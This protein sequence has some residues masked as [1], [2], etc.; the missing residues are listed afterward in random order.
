[1]KYVGP[2]DPDRLPLRRGV[3]YRR[4]HST[5]CRHRRLLGSRRWSSLENRSTTGARLL[6]ERRGDGGGGGPYWTGVLGREDC[7]QAAT[8]AGSYPR[9]LTRMRIQQRIAAKSTRTGWARVEGG[10]PHWLTACDGP[11]MLAIGFQV[12]EGIERRL[13]HIEFGYCFSI[14]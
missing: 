6:G 7:G 1:M 3:R 9:G 12:A 8:G 2:R 14:R 11:S 10:P 4:I 5:S 13:P